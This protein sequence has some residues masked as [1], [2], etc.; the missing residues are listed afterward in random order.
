MG[1]EKDLRLISVNIGNFIMKWLSDKSGFECRSFYGEAFSLSLLEGLEILDDATRM[2]L[3]NSYIKLDKEDSQF[4]WEFNNY[5]LLNYLNMKND[6]EIYDF[7][8]PLKFKHTPVTNWTLLR[9]NA[10]L[11]AKQDENKAISEALSKVNNFQLDS[12]L[13]LDQKQDE[14]FQYHCFSIA[15]IGEIYELTNREEFYKS[16][17][18]GV[19]FIRNFILSTGDT[20]YIGRGQKQSFGYGA[21]IYILTLAYKFTEDNSL[22]N[23]IKKV[24]N[25]LVRHQ[26]TDGSFPLVLNGI[27]QPIPKKVN[28]EDPSYVGWYPYNNYFDYLP[29]MG[30][31]VLKASNVLHSLNLDK[32]THDEKVSYS[33][34][35]FIVEKKSKYEAVVSKTGGYWTNDMPIPYIISDGKSITPCY[36]GEQFQKSLFSVKGLP[37]PYCH[38][39]KK[40]IRWRGVSFLKNDTLTILSPL[41]IMKRM[42]IFNENSIVIKTKIYS[43]FKFIHV[44]LF[45]KQIK[46]ILPGKLTINNVEITSK[47]TLVPNKI[48]YSTDGELQL[49]EDMGKESIIQFDFNN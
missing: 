29:F 36:G 4:H 24:K 14:S 21:L 2:K 3:V 9:S 8:Y 47:N 25:L 18:S 22:L 26:H 12:G 33:D 27:E 28:I 46:Q 37:L 6:K 13:I 30:Y 7:I 49:F 19:N 11:L 45:K 32:S 31:F 42:F 34:K 17:I 10:R 15:M 43:P 39:L 40:S 38:S 23:D 1:L 5:A 35:N 44:Y 20:T 48:E 16:F 41:G